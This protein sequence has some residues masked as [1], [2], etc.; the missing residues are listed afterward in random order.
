MKLEIY[1]WKS[2]KRVH[3]AAVCLITSVTSR[4]ANADLWLALRSNAGFPLVEVNERDPMRS[5]LSRPLTHQLE[6]TTTSPNLSCSCYLFAT[7]SPQ[8][9]AHVKVKQAD[10]GKFLWDFRIL[11]HALQ[12]MLYRVL[13][14]LFL[15]H[16]ST[17]YTLVNCSEFTGS[18][19]DL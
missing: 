3:H 16:S 5:P 6:V 15:A 13:M 11:I 9:H 17:N 7:S 4:D 2:I 12:H 14:R 18:N 8:R 19:N 10:E 1:N